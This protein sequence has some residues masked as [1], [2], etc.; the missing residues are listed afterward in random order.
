MGV[1]AVTPTLLVAQVVPQRLERE[2]QV[3]LFLA[4][5]VVVLWRE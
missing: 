4:A 3:C 2:H 5:M 1:A